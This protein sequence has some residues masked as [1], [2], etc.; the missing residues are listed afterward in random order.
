[1]V[2][3]LRICAPNTGG[4]DLIHRQE[5]RPCMPQLRP[6][7]EINKYFFFKAT[8]EPKGPFEYVGYG[9]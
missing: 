2:Q 1:M 4:S 9:Y 7:T 5:T 6:S 3:W 8:E